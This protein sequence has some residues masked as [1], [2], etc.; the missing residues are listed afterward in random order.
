MKRITAFAVGVFLLLLSALVADGH[1]SAYKGNAKKAEFNAFPKKE[2]KAK[3]SSPSARRKIGKYSGKWKGTLYQPD[4][5]LR[6]K[7]GFAMR[8]YQKGKTVS[9]FSRITVIDSPQYYGV[10]RLKGTVKKNRLLFREVKITQENIETDQRW[11]IKSGNLKLT[12]IKGKLTLKGKWKAPSCPA[13]TI[14]LRRVSV[15]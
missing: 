4:G 5:T 12:Y 2:N 3:P 1:L 10:M 7:F 15:K 6:A 9:G 11:C 14:V 8:L 13:G